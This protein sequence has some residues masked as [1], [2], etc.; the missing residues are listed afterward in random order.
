[1]GRVRESHRGRP[2]V[3][4]SRAPTGARQPFVYGL[5]VGLTSC[6]E[7]MKK[8]AII[9][10]FGAIAVVT[11]VDVIGSR[12]HSG[13]IITCGTGGADNCIRD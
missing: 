10:L 8:F 1:M 7:I 13:A 11:F 12:I 4:A 6:E 3:T 2:L 5:R 9:I